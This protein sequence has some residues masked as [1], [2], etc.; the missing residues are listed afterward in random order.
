MRYWI[1][2]TPSSMHILDFWNRTR[3]NWKNTIS[4]HYPCFLIHKLVFFVCR[5]NHINSKTHVYFKLLC[6]GWIAGMVSGVEAAIHCGDELWFSVGMEISLM[7]YG[8]INLYSTVRLYFSLQ[9]K[10]YLLCRCLHN[11]DVVL[12]PGTP[13]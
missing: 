10:I 8:G 4:E 7:L 6:P 11:A 13:Q 9:W 12:Y 5:T 3:I 2:S 1:Y